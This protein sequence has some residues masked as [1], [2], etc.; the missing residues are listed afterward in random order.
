MTC[1][2]PSSICSVFAAFYHRGPFERAETCA[3]FEEATE[4]FADDYSSTVPDPDHSV[5]E[6]QLYPIWQ[7]QNRPFPGR[8]RSQ[9][10]VVESASSTQ[11]Q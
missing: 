5:D 11:G 10:A 6:E 3:T 8:K 9:T 7:D 4:V 2:V 1:A